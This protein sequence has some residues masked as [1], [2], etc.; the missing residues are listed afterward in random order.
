MT[1]EERSQVIKCLEKMLA[2]SYENMAN[3]T[4]N[5]EYHFLDNVLSRKTL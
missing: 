5:D 2:V 3:N 4:Y 1:Q